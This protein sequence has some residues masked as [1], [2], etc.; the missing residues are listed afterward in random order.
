MRNRWTRFVHDAVRAL[1]AISL[2]DLSGT[3]SY[4]RFVREF[5]SGLADTHRNNNYLY[6]QSQRALGLIVEESPAARKAWLQ[7]LQDDG[8]NL[9]GMGCDRASWSAYSE[10]LNDPEKGRQG[11]RYWPLMLSKAE[12]RAEF[13][14]YLRASEYSMSVIV[15]AERYRRY[16]QYALEEAPALV[17][18]AFDPDADK[19]VRGAAGSALLA[20]GPR[21][22]ALL[23][24]LIAGASGKRPRSVSRAVPALLRTDD[25][26]IWVRLRLAADRGDGYRNDREKSTARR[27][28][29]QL[30]EYLLAFPPRSP[31][32]LELFTM[33]PPSSNSRNRAVRPRWQPVLPRAAVERRLGN[34]SSPDAKLQLLTQIEPD[35]AVELLQ[36]LPE[37]QRVELGTAARRKKLIAVNRLDA[38]LPLLPGDGPLP[39]MRPGVTSNE[40][41]RHASFRIC[42]RHRGDHPRDRAVRLQLTPGVSPSPRRPQGS[43]QELCRRYGRRR[44]HG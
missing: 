43:R 30:E 31:R 11:A 35:L 12:M 6:S 27:Q 15:F 36:A 3:A 44:V 28:S 9:N 21:V 18:L 42:R 10:Y 40:E 14:A 19:K 4:S 20:M 5:T 1:D 26:A 33:P 25:D 24:E 39:A 22:A 16:P 17:E 2:K 34:R 23:P 8:R 29:G 7:A 41:L 13:M 32:D 37:E 38:L